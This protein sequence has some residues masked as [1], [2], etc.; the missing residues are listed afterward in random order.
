MKAAG[1]SKSLFDASAHE[2]LAFIAGLMESDGSH[3]T[4]GNLYTFLQSGKEHQAI[5]EDLDKLARSVG[6]TTSGVFHL[7]RG[8]SGLMSSKD[9]F[10]VNLLQGCETFQSFLAI[11]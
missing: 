8:K 4:K 9:K 11:E 1:F 7:K 10:Q 5:V 3:Q 6:I 2:R